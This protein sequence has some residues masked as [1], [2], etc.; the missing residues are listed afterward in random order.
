MIDVILGKSKT[1]KTTHIYNMIEQ[2]IKENYNVILFVPSQSRAKAENEYMKILN[3]DGVIGINITTISEFVKEE[4]KVQNLHMNEKSMSKL[5]RKIILTQVIKENPKL[6]NIFDKVKNYP[7]FLDVLDIYMDLFRKNNIT[8]DKYKDVILEDKR[9]NEK[10]KEILAIYDKYFEIMNKNYVD[11][12]EEMDLFIKNIDNSFYFNDTK[13]L[14]IYFDG[15]NNFSN[16]EYKL[17]DALMK[18]NVKIAITLNTDITKIEDVYTSSSI[19]EVSNDTYKRICQIANKNNCELQNIVKYDNIF[20]SK[21]DIKFVANNIFNNNC[22]EKVNLENIQVLMYTNVLKEIEN[23]ARIIS[24]KVKEGNRFS[25]FAIYT[26][27]IDEYENAISRIFYEN[28]LEVYVSKSKSIGESILTKYIQGILKLAIKGLNLELIF[29]ILKLGI[30]DIDLKDI[31]LLENYMKEFNVNK[32]LINN[33]FTLNNQKESYDLENLNKIKDK[34]V[35]MYS[36]TLSMKKL[37]AKEFILNIYNHLQSERIFEN[38]SNIIKTN[39][40][41]SLALNTLNFENQV[42]ENI[43]TIFDSIIKIYKDDILTVEEFFNIFNLVIKDVK[44]KTLPPT[45]DQI[46]LLDINVAKTGPKKY[47]FF[48]GVT[49]GKFPKNVDE[50]IFFT[51]NELESLKEKEVDIRE[52]SI[53]KLNMGFFNIYEALNNVKEK[54]YIT[55]PSATLD[56]KATRKSSFITLLEQIS[57]FNIEGEVTNLNIEQN[58][59]NIYS[60]DELFMWLISK[61]RDFDNISDSEKEQVISVYEYFKSDDK[62]S[63]ILKFKKDDSKLSDEV[64][65]IV[66]GKEFK[67]SVSKLE[68]YKKCPFSYFMQYVL[69]INPNKE[70]KLNVLELGSFMHNV[71]ENFSMYLL[72]KGISWQEI[73]TEDLESI[74]TQY[75]SVLEEIINIAIEKNLSKQ[76]QSVRYMVLKRKLFN[77][78]K[79]VIHTVALSYNQSEFEP[80]GY[81]IEFKDNSIFLP[82]QIQLD[83]SHVMKIIGKIDRVDMLKYKDE[84]YVRVVDYKSSSKDLN[85]DKIKEGLSLQL[86]TYLMAFI[87]NKKELKIKPAGMLYFNLSDKLVALTQYEQNNENIKKILMKKL[88]MNGIFLNDIEILNKMDRNFEN[89]S[90]MSLINVSKKSISSSGK[91]VL[92]EDEFENLCNETKEILKQIGK[93]IASGIVEI[94]PNKKEN[95]CQFCNYSTNCRKNLEV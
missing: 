60:K 39:K 7:G 95:Y 86:I 43:A 91:K 8:L 73:L 90:A 80:Y 56:G 87:E 28:N 9:T 78:M 82:M 6:F 21:N 93:N 13:K 81:E 65:N 66:Y 41:D 55:I 25:D 88:K 74:E 67:T 38:F 20:S 45:K 47:A 23:V 15:Y 40:K 68:L 31:Y 30:T 17:I 34:I 76:K 22:N 46:E 94:N 24:Q 12:V 11:S 49:E 72:N 26:T 59:F 83:E 1:G 16:S 32:Y 61:I 53:T 3:K 27:N 58:I 69:N 75:E 19:F 10:F 4:L 84:N 62:Y 70:A 48:I 29:D 37:T 50:D 52:T 35:N 42:W 92:K 89:N 71:L 79:K 64:T 44:I 57:N 5:D 36:F 77:T 63:K 14:R 33:K 51:D 18:R 2:D 85:I 54:L